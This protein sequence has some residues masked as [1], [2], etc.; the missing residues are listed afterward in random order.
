MFTQAGSWSWFEVCVVRPTEDDP[1]KFEVKVLPDGHAA[2]WCSHKHP[3]ES[4]EYE[5]HRGVLFDFDHP[6]WDHVEEGD[7]LAVGLKARF[8]GWINH[9]RHGVLEVNT[10][11]EPSPEMLSLMYC[12]T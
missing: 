10:W 9:A 7:A 11:W 1:S 5:E 3:I 2:S 12:E 8:G 4:Q 6:I